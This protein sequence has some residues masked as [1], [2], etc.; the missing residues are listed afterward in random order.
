M[1]LKIQLENAREFANMV[2]SKL[3]ENPSDRSWQLAF[4]E[5]NYV[6]KRLDV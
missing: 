4:I 3:L 6:Y 1:D 5:A 2:R